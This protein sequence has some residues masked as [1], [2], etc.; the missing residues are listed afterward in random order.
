MD[1]KNYWHTMTKQI[2]M[3]HESIIK[4]QAQACGDKIFIPTFFLINKTL[5]Y[6]SSFPCMETQRKNKSLTN[7]LRSK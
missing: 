4:F 6:I 5:S 2:P 1:E 3:H 7:N